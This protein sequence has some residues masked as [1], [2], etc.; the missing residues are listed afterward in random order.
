MC[1][2]VL[3]L[4]HI[5][6]EYRSSTWEP[7]IPVPFILTT[8]FLHMQLILPQCLHFF[9]VICH[10]LFQQAHTQAVSLCQHPFHGR[11]LSS[12]R[13]SYHHHGN[14]LQDWLLGGVWWFTHQGTRRFWVRC[15]ECHWY[16]QRREAGLHRGQ[17]HICEGK[18]CSVSGT[19]ILYAV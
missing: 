13:R 10:S 1:N 4:T 7:P 15:A 18:M 8:F 2:S 9:V 19:C 17:W 5:L 3:Q 14:W 11:L 12:Q 16:Q 6:L